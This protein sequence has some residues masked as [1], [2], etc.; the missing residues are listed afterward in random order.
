[1]SREAREK[2]TARLYKHSL[3]TTGRLPTGKET[4]AMEKKSVDIAKKSD[5]KRRV[6]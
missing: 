2:L 5:L 1:M 6:K 4:R 3:K